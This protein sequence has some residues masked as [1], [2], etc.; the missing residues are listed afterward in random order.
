MI[1]GR[2]AAVKALE[3]IHGKGVFSNKILSDYSAMEMSTED[4]KLLRELVY[5]VLENQLYIDGIIRSV[6]KV[7]MRKIHPIVMEI[8]RTAIYQIIFV[9]RIPP[10]AAI[11]EA[12][13]LAKK[14]GHK[15]TVGYVNGMLRKID[16]QLDEL[17]LSDNPK[18]MQELA[19]RYSHPEY[20]V[21]LWMREYGFDFAK[22]LVRANNDIPVLNIRVN[23]LKT[24]R[25]TL[26]KILLNKGLV[27]KDGSYSQDCLKVMNPDKITEFDEFK[28]GLFT[29]QDESSMLVAE[30]ANPAEGDLVID[31]CSAPGG[32]ATHMAQKMNNRGRIIARDLYSNKLSLIEETAKRLGIEI[33][34]TQ[35]HDASVFDKDLE[36]KAD[37]CIVDAPCSGFGL[38]RRKPDIKLN[39]SE[40]DVTALV[41]IQEKILETSSRYVK[42]GGLLIYSTCTINNAE[43]IDQVNLF[44]KK[45]D[46]FALEAIELDDGKVVSE[47]QDHGIIELFPNV[48]GTDG[49]FISKIRRNDGK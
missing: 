7:P 28:E 48:H 20:L 8:L 1:T 31:V 4:R 46:E 2:D 37:I 35:A 33:I 23:T 34:E 30:T 45:H 15:G 47:K 5:G 14:Y 27:V 19:A 3:Q 41:H 25:S 22:N 9:G 43:N 16:R 17:I 11:N 10:R 12:V 13:E 29:I 38:I 21:K 6:S 24:D 49:F 44:L 32:K 40:D 26:S 18:T 42:P 39:R 36:N